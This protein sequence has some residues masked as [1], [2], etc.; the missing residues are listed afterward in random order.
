VAA[1]GE[2]FCGAFAEGARHGPGLLRD[3]GAPGAPRRVAFNR[4]ELV[5]PGG[6]GA[7]VPPRARAPLHHRGRARTAVARRSGALTGGSA[8]GGG[9]RGR[10]PRRRW[11]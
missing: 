1:D 5:R 10:A 2:E 8:R 6:A 3:P 11:G 9:G 7:E 4:G